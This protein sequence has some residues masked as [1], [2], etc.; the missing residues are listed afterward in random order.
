MV[1]NFFVRRFR[2]WMRSP[3]FYLQKAA[4]RF[5]DI[6]NAKLF[7]QSRETLPPGSFEWLVLTETLYGG[8]Q[9]GGVNSKTNRGGDRMSPHYHGYGRCYAAFLKPFISAA[10]TRKL[11]LVEVGILN[12]NGLATWCDLF[13]N[14]RIIG[15][16][17]DLS[18]FQANRGHLKE[19]GA[20]QKNAP[21]LYV[22]DQLDAARAKGV[23]SAV[24]GDSR[25]DIAID[26]G[27]DNSRGNN[28]CRQPLTMSP[29]LMMLILKCA[30]QREKSRMLFGC[31][32]LSSWRIW[33][34]SL[35]S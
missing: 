7:Q 33:K 14:A 26:D 29:V 28:S 17:I 32:R 15:F 19:M 27:L 3:S 18:N 16:D 25:V 22:F 1:E 12:G 21:E 24:L 6:S 8:L 20:F 2:S 10:R 5:F 4:E 34:R 30:K 23:M 11:T 9:L 13:P 31:R 35:S